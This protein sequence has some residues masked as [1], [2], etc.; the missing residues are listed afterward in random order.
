M[1]AATFL[2]IGVREQG[3]QRADW[4]HWLPPQCKGSA[5]AMAGDGVGAARAALPTC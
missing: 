2:G 1:I 4:G 5:A 3:R